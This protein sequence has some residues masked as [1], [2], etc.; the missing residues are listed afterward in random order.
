MGSQPAFLTRLR[1]E[2]AEVEARLDLKDHDYVQRLR[3]RRI[4]LEHVHLTT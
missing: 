3:L 4:V 2:R 1:R